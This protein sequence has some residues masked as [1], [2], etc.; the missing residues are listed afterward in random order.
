MT[1]I[2]LN[3]YLNIMRSNGS[4]LGE[5]RKNNADMI[6]NQNFTGDIGYRKAYIL[7]PKNGWHYEDIIFSRHGITSTSKS[8]V[9]S[10]VQFR[11]QKRFPIGTYLFIPDE[12]SYELTI[13]KE[14][15]LCSQ[16][17]KLWFIVDKT[18][19][20]QFVR[21]LVIKCDYLLK[22]VTD[23]GGKRH[24]EKCWAACQAANSY[25]SCRCSSLY[26]KRYMCILLNCWEDS[27]ESYTPQRS[28]KQQA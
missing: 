19:Y 15:P 26:R 2:Q 17:K 11:P 24:I 27:L 23:F 1:M 20:R 8:G 6:V 25:T 16:A 9:D 5:I 4:S 18:D 13:N 14:D 10:Y 12:E 7:D 21:Y 3:D 22:W 28:W